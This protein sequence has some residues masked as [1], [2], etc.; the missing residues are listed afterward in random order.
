MK[1][2]AILLGICFL[3]LTQKSICQ[4]SSNQY[5]IE[6]DNLLQKKNPDYHSGLNSILSD[7]EEELIAKRIIQDGTFQSYAELLKQISKEKK[8]DFS[9]SYDLQN[10]LEKL[11]DGISKMM[12]SI[13]SSLISKKYL[14]QN[15]SKDFV[16]YQR[17]SKMS[18]SGMK[19]DRSVIAKTLLEVYNE[20]DLDLPMVKLKIFRLI[21]P[22][23]D[24]IIYTY[25]GRPYR[26]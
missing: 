22:K 6:I 17:L 3:V 12:L 8:P 1:Q 26:D 19:L 14:N 15:N 16:L 5:E 25:V 7:F 20:E 23:V 2:A 21:D 18:N 9:I 4:V 13:E 11:G 10:S 24:F